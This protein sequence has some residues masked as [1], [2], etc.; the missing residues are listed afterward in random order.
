MMD[1]CRANAAT[2]NEPGVALVDGYGFAAA[3]GAMAV[4]Q[5]LAALVLVP[6]RLR[7][8]VHTVPSHS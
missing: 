1:G 3:F 2:V 7:Q 4:S 5:V 6:L 8:V